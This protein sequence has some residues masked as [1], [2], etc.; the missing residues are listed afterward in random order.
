MMFALITFIGILVIGG[1][2]YYVCAETFSDFY[3][4]MVTEYPD[5]ILNPEVDFLYNVVAWLP[6][7]ILIIAIVSAIVIELRRNR[8]DAYFQ[9]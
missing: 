7:F 8:P 4:S 9:I 6:L 3:T 2:T 5:W 1:L